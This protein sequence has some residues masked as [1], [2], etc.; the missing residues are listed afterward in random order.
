MSLKEAII[1]L[2]ITI[3]C[4]YI[5]ATYTILRQCHDK[6]QLDRLKKFLI[7]FDLYV[8]KGMISLQ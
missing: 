2:K 1:S 7:L 8:R 5:K 4:H 6:N 3:I